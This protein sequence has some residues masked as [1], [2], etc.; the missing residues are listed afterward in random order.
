MTGNQA[1]NAQIKE[2]K[3]QIKSGRLESV[4]EVADD[5]AAKSVGRYMQD[6][7]KG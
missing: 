7:L 5:Y 4:A 3:E 6:R 1:V 2:D